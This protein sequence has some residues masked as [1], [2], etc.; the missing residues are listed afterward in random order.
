LVGCADK[1][2]FSGTKILAFG[3]D[4]TSMY[5]RREGKSGFDADIGFG[6]CSNIACLEFH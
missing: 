4:C 3:G 5:W 1:S 2:L 6:I